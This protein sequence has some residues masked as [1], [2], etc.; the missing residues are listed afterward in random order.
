MIISL[1]C[2][3]VKIS[4]ETFYAWLKTDPKFAMAYRDLELSEVDRAEGYL[5]VL[6]R[7]RNHTGFMAIAMFLNN[8]APDRWQDRRNLNVQAQHQISGQIIY[9]TYREFMDSIPMEEVLAAKR[10]NKKPIKRID[11]A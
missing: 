3:A 2:E 9:G 5:R 8:R 10:G 1:A 7:Q 11:R 4:R 6:M